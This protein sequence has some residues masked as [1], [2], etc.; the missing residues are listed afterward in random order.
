M[1]RVISISSLIGAMVGAIAFAEHDIY[2]PSLICTGWM[3]IWLLCQKKKR[4]RAA[5]RGKTR[6]NVCQTQILDFYRTTTT[7]DTQSK[8]WT[9]MGK[10]VAPM[11]FEE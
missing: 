6:K 11:H 10:A 8:I 2:I 3:A 5:T 4:P 7:I 1:Q 9:P